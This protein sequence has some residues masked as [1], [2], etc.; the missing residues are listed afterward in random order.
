M[1]DE[2]QKLKNS[3][4]FEGL[5]SLKGVG[6][7]DEAIPIDT[8]SPILEIFL[9]YVHSAPSSQTRC[10]FFSGSVWFEVYDLAR[11]LDC[12]EIACRILATF[13]GTRLSQAEYWGLMRKLS[14]KNDVQSARKVLGHLRS[15]HLTGG[16]F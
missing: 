13:D 5:L 10:H 1:H 7:I 14:E 12:T 6:S 4:F 11:T 16:K 8:S 9:N 3:T 2:C 15:K